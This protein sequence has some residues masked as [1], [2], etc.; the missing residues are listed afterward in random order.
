MRLKISSDKILSL[1]AI[2]I[3][4][5]SVVVT[6]WEGA[7]IRKHNRLSVRPKLEI[8]FNHSSD[9]NEMEWIL[10]N[11]G[12]GPGIIKSSH[13]YV[14]DKEYPIH[15]G[16][17]YYE[18]IDSLAVG[19]ITLAKFSSLNAGLAIKEGTIKFIVRFKLNSGISAEV[20]RKLHDRIKF[21]IKYESMYTE[22]FCCKYP[23]EK[24]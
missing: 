9:E 17:V 24:R 12:I 15:N 16:A 5:A 14:D 23:M 11:N 8:F 3:A 22:I 7:E 20:L 4:L 2:I 13:I 10:C 1:S 6:I 19:G 21:E 18:I